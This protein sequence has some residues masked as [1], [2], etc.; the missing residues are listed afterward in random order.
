MQ[1]G[2][3]ANESGLLVDR[4]RSIDVAV[5]A[6]TRRTQVNALEALG[7][8][9]EPV[10]R[11]QRVCVAYHR[12]LLGAEDEADT[13]QLLVKRLESEDAEHRVPP[14]IAKK[15]TDAI[16]RSQ[17][18]LQKVEELQPECQRQVAH[19]AVQYQGRR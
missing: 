7:F 3:V 14:E 11:A 9:T 13:A 10:L 5:D 17:T 19:L 2:D 15:A 1:Q 6:E 12:A 8:Q 16:R 18:S 4:V